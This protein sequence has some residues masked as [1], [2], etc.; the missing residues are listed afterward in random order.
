MLKQISLHK[1]VYLYDNFPTKILLK[2]YLFFSITKVKH[3]HHK[4]WKIETS[5]YS[6]ITTV[7]I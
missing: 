3:V 4:I 6:E 7:N 1:F 5:P 2:Q